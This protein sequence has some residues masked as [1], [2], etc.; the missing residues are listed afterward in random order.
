MSARWTEARLT[1]TLKT[2]SPRARR[3]PLSHGFSFSSARRVAEVRESHP[4]RSSGI[5]T[6]GISAHVA[7]GRP[8]R[9]RRS[10]T[11]PGALGASGSGV[12][13]TRFPCRI[14]IQSPHFGRGT[15]SRSHALAIAHG[16]ISYSCAS[17]VIGILQT[18]SYSSCLVIVMGVMDEFESAAPS[19]V[20]SRRFFLTW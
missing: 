15:T 19:W 7:F 14:L 2:P 5:G 20:S 10:V 4:R 16:V 11:E 18:R 3:R 1:L 12:F 13:L 9:H 8:S 6:L 17:F